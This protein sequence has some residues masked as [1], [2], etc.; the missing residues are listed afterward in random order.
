ML[1]RLRQLCLEG[2]DTEMSLYGVKLEELGS[3]LLKSF[4]RIIIYVQV[5]PVRV[6]WRS[7]AEKR[8]AAS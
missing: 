7:I 1:R 3:G 6:I 2:K 4:W 5:I 8:S